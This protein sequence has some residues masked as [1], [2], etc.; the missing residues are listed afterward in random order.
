MKK[1]KALGYEGYKCKW[2][3]VPGYARTWIG[4]ETTSSYLLYKVKHIMDENAN[5]IENWFFK[6]DLE[7]VPKKDFSYPEIE[8]LISN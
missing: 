8:Y 4:W 3:V 6:F 2:V 1:E 5:P 7:W